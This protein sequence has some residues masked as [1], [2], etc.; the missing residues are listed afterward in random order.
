[1]VL[2]FFPFGVVLKIPFSG[3]YCKLFSI[4]I[5]LL[6]KSTERQRS[7]QI[8]PRLHPLSS[9]RRKPHVRGD[10]PSI[11]FRRGK[12]LVCAPQMWG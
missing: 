12:M 5:V 2:L 6:M 11:P 7:P 3:V 1:M 10:E 9:I 4:V 8:S